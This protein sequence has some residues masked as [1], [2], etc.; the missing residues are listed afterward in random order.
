MMAMKGLKR[1]GV[2]AWLAVTLLFALLLLP[3]NTSWAHALLLDS[4]PGDQQVLTHSPSVIWLRFS[5]PLQE[6][7]FQIRLFNAQGKKI[8]LSPQLDP[9][10]P[11]RVVS[12]I[13]SLP[14]GTYT[15]S[16][17]V[18]SEDG[19][20]VAG[21][22]SFSV[23]HASS[24]K[25]APLLAQDAHP[26]NWLSTSWH[27]ISETALL[28][29]GGLNWAA[30]WFSRNGFPSMKTLIRR[31]KRQIWLLFCVV[32]VDGILYVKTLPA[33]DWTSGTMWLTSL[34]YHNVQMILGQLLLLLLLALPDMVEGWYLAVWLFLIF[35]FAF[36]GHV[37]STS[38]FWTAWFLREVH[39]GAIALW[40]G[41][42]TYLILLY[43]L[44]REENLVLDE[45]VLHSE[46]FHLAS[47]SALTILITGLWMVSVQSD[48]HLVIHGITLWISLL[49]GKLA[50]FVVMLVIALVQ[51]IIGRKKQVYNRFLL[52]IEWL[53]GVLVLFL[54]V[55]LSHSAFPAPIQR[56][57]QILISHR[58]KAQVEIARLQ[59]G[60]QP[61]TVKLPLHSP[62][63][64]RMTVR[65]SAPDHQVKFPSVPLKRNGSHQYTGTI[66]F[67]FS[68]TWRIN[69]E[70]EYTDGTY[71]EWKDQVEIRG[72][73]GP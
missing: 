39:T 40:L 56:Y 60:R 13:P 26:L 68:G 34:K 50:L 47:A 73:E 7:L 33:L 55:W 16:W 53:I 28:L 58:Q 37:W 9:H 62:E 17:N 54:G 22:I 61:I 70:A 65:V 24:A 10:D 51:T 12:A 11:S 45:R 18:V 43:R 46:V 29:L 20:P 71:G 44:K 67:T 49:W 72:G 1:H 25:K 5:E 38:D 30:M 19:H 66:P 48:W 3:G 15:V 8:T 4:N 64:E 23:G 6:G 57:D 31:K 36:G 35:S 2:K 59:T 14:N 41:I 32:L 63:P 42:L 52:R 69:I 27:F 21:A